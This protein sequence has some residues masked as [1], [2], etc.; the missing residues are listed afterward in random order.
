MGLGDLFSLNM[1]KL[2]ITIIEKG[3]GMHFRFF[4]AL[5]ML[6]LAAL[7]CQA[8]VSDGATSTPS[9]VL[10]QDDFSNNTSGWDRISTAEGITDYADGFY[11][12]FVNIVDSDIWA[13]PGLDFTDVRL[14]VDASKVAG[15]DNNV[16]GL[17]CRYQDNDNF[18]FLV[19]SSDGYYGIGK[20]KGGVQKLVG[21][22][23]MPPIDNIN[24]GSAL[25]HLRA[26]CIGNRLA[27]YVNGKKAGEQTDSDFPSGDVGLFAGAFDQAGTDIHFD[28]FSVLK[29]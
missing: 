9:N 2:K 8:V 16:F 21:M 22:E 4:V 27:L 26:D 23:S 11:R 5:A 20:L 1:L 25:N 24:P 12:I 18:Y 13:N 3:C 28:N 14:E 19:A 15:D 6:A 10:F 7:A 17:I 29:P